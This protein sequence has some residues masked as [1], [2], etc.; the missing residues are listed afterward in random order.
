M[1]AQQTIRRG[2]A[3]L[4]AALATAVLA[5]CGTS[6]A[7]GPA[8]AAGPAGTSLVPGIS[9]PPAI[10]P[11]PYAG[12]IGDK[13][14]P[15]ITPA[16]IPP[17]GSAAAVSLP[18]DTYIQTS[19]QQSQTLDG[20]AAQVAQR[21]TTAAGFSF[22]VQTEPD[23]QTL[24]DQLIEHRDGGLASVAQARAYG[25][26]QPPGG[27]K[28]PTKVIT[29]LPSFASEQRKH[30]SGWAS[31]LLGSVPGTKPGSA[32]LGCLRAANAL[33]FGNL[34]GNL[35]NGLVGSM[36]FQSQTWADSDPQVLRVQRAWSACMAQHHQNY[37]S[38]VLLEWGRTW[39]D[40][41]TRA[42]ISLAVTDARCVHQ[43]NLANTYLTVEA[44]YQHAVLS[45]NLPDVQQAQ[46]DFG[47]MQQRAQQVLAL[48]AAD[49]LRFSRAKVH[50]AGYLL[51]PRFHG[52]HAGV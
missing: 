24:I 14:R 34:N 7:R 6:G 43:V 44:A 36:L 1:P 37:K 20:A 52:G 23:D 12:T 8:P 40:P 2:C 45:Q 31:A 11:N 25:F 41:P 5:A 4:T 27:F 15:H 46:A 22:P 18:L 28:A 30:G 16:P 51:V 42:E 13:V 35:E 33:V 21:C 10:K 48:P 3:V 29:P 49:I 26:Q 38:T 50:Q 39:P 9:G 19:V 47:T 32:P 17:A